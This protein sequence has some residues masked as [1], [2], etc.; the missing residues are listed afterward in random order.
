M[1]ITILGTILL[2]SLLGYIAY[3]TRIVR[4]AAYLELLSKKTT[5]Y[6]A[7]AGSDN[8]DEIIPS[9][10]EIQSLEHKIF[11]DKNG[12][13]FNSNEFLHYIVQ[14]E[15][16]QFCGIHNN[17]IIFADAN[18][19]IKDNIA[20]PVILV[21]RKHHLKGEDKAQYKIRRTW[22]HYNYVSKDDLVNIVETKIIPSEAFQEIRQLD[23]YDG[24]AALIQDLKD[25]RIQI[26][27]DE[28]IN[29]GNPNEND[30]EI[31]ISTTF[32]TKERKIR[33]SIH[34][35]SIVVGKVVA[36]FP[37]QIS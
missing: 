13:I 33:F 2:F 12:N 32:H 37:V 11:K 19:K 18:F 35:T 17:D 34:P 20:F 5:V 9:Q 28:Y 1:I 14:G 15:S 16:M 23:T 4:K 26:Y 25:K 29:C 27:E 24:D 21:L 22:I 7:C 3:H 8:E 36:S 6:T 30:R 31:I 10:K